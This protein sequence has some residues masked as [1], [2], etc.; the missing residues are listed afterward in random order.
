MPAA[1]PELFPSL[2]VY[3]LALLVMGGA[4]LI[5]ATVGAGMFA[6]S[7]LA[8]LLPDLT[9]I[10]V[11]L[12]ILSLLTEIWVLSQTWRETNRPLMLGLLVPMI[13]GLIGGTYIL[14]TA[15]VTYLKQLLGIVV[16]FA[17]GW[18]LLG[19]SSAGATGAR[20]RADARF[21]LSVPVG[22][23]SGILGGL[24]GTGGPPVIIYLRGFG[25]SKGTFRA[26][27]L[28]F[29]FVMSAARTVAYSSGGLLT[30]TQLYAALWLLPGTLAGTLLG[31]H[32]HRQLPDATFQRIVAGLLV[33]LGGLLVSGLGR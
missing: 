1:L 20:H 21:W 31:M 29:F 33:L 23:L 9:D 32:V 10:V 18:F 6:V 4:A 26:T 12:L 19:R 7:L 14:A 13:M 27:I 30:T 28:S 25:L 24:F 15:D 3:V 5:Y 2:T 17:G 11:V 16:M 22:L 8:L